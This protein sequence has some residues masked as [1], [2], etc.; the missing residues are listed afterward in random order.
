MSPAAPVPVIAGVVALVMSS[1]LAPLSLAGARVSPVGTGA[2][3]SMVSA[4]AAEGPETLPAASVS[5]AV[6]L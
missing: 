3:V 1:P 4:R 6:T 5:V 2:V